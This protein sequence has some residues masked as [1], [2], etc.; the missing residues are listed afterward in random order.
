MITIEKDSKEG[1]KETPLPH[2]SNGQMMVPSNTELYLSDKEGKINNNII[3]TYNK[4][5]KSQSNYI[6]CFLF[7]NFFF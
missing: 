7:R 3:I 2:Y 6:T 4:K 1:N 5:Y